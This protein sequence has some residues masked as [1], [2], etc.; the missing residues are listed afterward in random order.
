MRSFGGDQTIRKGAGLIGLQSQRSLCYYRFGRIGI[1]PL[2][3]R[4]SNQRS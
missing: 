1:L 3:Y 4:K 2:K